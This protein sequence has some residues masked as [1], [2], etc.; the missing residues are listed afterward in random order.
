MFLRSI[1]ELI[2]LDGKPLKLLLICLKKCSLNPVNTDEGNAICVNK[3]FKNT[4]REYGLDITDAAI[5]VY[6]SRL[7]KLG[8]LIRQCR[9]YYLL[10]P[11]YFFK[12]RI[13]DSTKVSMK[14]SNA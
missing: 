14:L 5:D 11:K 7:A 4:V 1:P 6:I 13:T 12:G 9:G 10:N 2:E 8:F 3:V